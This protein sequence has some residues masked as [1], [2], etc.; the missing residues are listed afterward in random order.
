[1]PSRSYRRKLRTSNYSK[2]YIAPSFLN[3]VSNKRCETNNTTESELVTIQNYFYDVLDMIIKN[4]SFSKAVDTLND[5]IL[6]IKEKTEFYTVL[7][8]IE[9]QLLSIVA[10]IADSTSVGIIQ[11]RIDYVKTIIDTL[12]PGCNEVGPISIMILEIIDSI[13]D[14]FNFTIVTKN[15]NELKTYIQ[16]KYGDFDQLIVIQDTLLSIICNIADGDSYG[17]ICTRIEYVKTL[18]SKL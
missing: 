1:M 5:I 3:R 2:S 7:E 6:K 4:D 11:C 12:P 8:V 16:D 9:N 18:I 10:N 14:N 15:I 13:K 17:I